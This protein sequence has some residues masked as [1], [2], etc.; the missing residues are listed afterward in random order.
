MPTL[1]PSLDCIAG[2]LAERFQKLYG[3]SPRIF[4]APGRANLIGEHTDY[5]DSFVMPAAIDSYT[6]VAV[7]KRPDRILNVYP[8]TLPKRCSCLWLP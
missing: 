7:A 8:S 4:L 3:T 5:N 6:W 1:V 2:S